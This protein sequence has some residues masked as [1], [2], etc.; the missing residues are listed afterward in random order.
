MNNANFI[1]SD[2]HFVKNS[3]MIDEHQI[4]KITEKTPELHNIGKIVCGDANS[5]ILTFEINRYYDN[6][7][8]LT[9]NIK[10]IVKNE[11]GT[12]TEDAINVQYSNEFLR[13]SWILSDSVTYKSG[14]VFAAIIFIGSESGNKYVLKTVPFTI[15]IETSLDFIEYDI[16]HKDWFTDI[17]YR[18]SILENGIAGTIDKNSLES[19]LFEGITNTTTLAENDLIPLISESEDGHKSISK[20]VTLP[21][22][23][24]E[25]AN[26]ID[27]PDG[28]I[29]FENLTPVT[30]L[31]EDDEFLVGT[32]EGNKKIG[33]KALAD[34]L[35]EMMNLE[36]STEEVSKI[37]FIR[38]FRIYMKDFN[39]TISANKNTCNIC[40][41][42]DFGISD[43]NLVYGIN[44]Y[45]LP[46][47]L[48]AY[49]FLDNNTIRIGRSSNFSTS[50]NKVVR[51]CL[52]VKDTEVTDGAG[53]EAIPLFPGYDIK[54]FTKT[55]N[56]S[57]G[58]MGIKLMDLSEAGILEEDVA[59]VVATCSTNPLIGTG[60]AGVGVIFENAVY[61]SASKAA[62]S[63]LTVPITFSIIY[64]KEGSV[65]TGLPD[66]FTTTD[67]PMAETITSED[68]LLLGTADGNKVVQNNMFMDF[69]RENGLFDLDGKGR[70]LLPGYGIVTRKVIIDHVKGGLS[71]DFCTIDELLGEIP[72]EDVVLCCATVISD[73]CNNSIGCYIDIDQNNVRG[74]WDYAPTI[75]VSDINVVVCAI[76]KKPIP[77][78]PGLK[79]ISIRENVTVS[80]HTGIACLL[81]EIGIADPSIIVSMS[82]KSYSFEGI[83]NVYAFLSNQ[84]VMIYY[85]GNANTYVDQDIEINFIVKDYSSIGP[86]IVTEGIRMIEKDVSFKT[87]GSQNTVILKE[88]D[89]DVN[90]DDIISVN[91]NSNSLDGYTGY[92]VLNAVNRT[93]ELITKAN[94][95]SGGIFSGKLSYFVKVPV[96]EQKLKPFTKDVEV[97]LI[98]E[99]GVA[100]GVFL[101]GSD[102]VGGYTIDNLHFY[103][104]SPITPNKVIHPLLIKNN[105]FFVTGVNE[106]HTGPCKIRIHIE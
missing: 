75:T 24:K 53:E 91:Y 82:A 64:R 57:S 29:A 18:L 83:T 61:F 7:D 37:P 50:E 95:S 52:I 51:I 16:E 87:G 102:D 86:S 8:L 90:F 47:G 2:D 72:P 55:Y 5:N 31:T 48:H 30:D 26:N 103:Y 14:N 41:L 70:P 3:N 98:G 71:V 13:F 38:G 88:A 19:T 65:L 21:T 23:A 60:W 35:K 105:E 96:V 34:G 68:K 39:V 27:I 36:I 80:N 56:I 94:T 76:Y 17:E 63:S 99:A 106:N 62:S 40:S 22:L 6:I 44:G 33:C 20:A 46:S 58:N 97:T 79:T 92:A 10:F 42:S 9:K 28:E 93:I 32:A 66:L 101:D 11:L 73:V 49:V 4:I 45:T 69:L 77:F 25:V 104:A 43:T 54:T 67:I 15:K 78:E 81:S 59:F 85:P 1:D 89:M 84:N 74:L 12:F 100:T